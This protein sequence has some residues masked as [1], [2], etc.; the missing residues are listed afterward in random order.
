LA[1]SISEYETQVVQALDEPDFTVVEISEAEPLR[2]SMS[3]VVVTEEIVALG[4]QALKDGLAWAAFY[5]YPAED[6]PE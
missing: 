1:S 6:D 5:A 4:G 2:E 3:R